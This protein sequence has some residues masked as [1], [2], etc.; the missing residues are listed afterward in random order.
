MRA[1][2]IFPKLASLGAML[3]LCLAVAAPA[4]AAVV[5]IG[6]TNLPVDTTSFSLTLNSTEEIDAFGFE[7]F[8]VKLS[9]SAPGAQFASVTGVEQLA[10][11][12]LWGDNVEGWLVTSHEASSVEVL[13]V[14]SHLPP[15]PA[16]D[17][18]KYT[19]NLTFDPSDPPTYAQ[20]I[21]A[22]IRFYD[23]GDEEVFPPGPLFPAVASV[24]IFPVTSIPEPSSWMLVAVGL[25]GLAWSR[26]AAAHK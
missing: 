18:L 9:F 11:L 17:L 8:R 16:G 2:R 22:A 14:G 12:P 26:C 24:T 13:F 10:G 6:P 21:T 19:F 15:L 1:E 7:F 23:I 3:A 4:H 5:F 25:M 20:Q